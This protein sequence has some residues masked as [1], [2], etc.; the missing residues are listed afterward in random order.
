MK[1]PVIVVLAVHRTRLLRCKVHIRI[2]SQHICFNVENLFIWL[3]WGN[4]CFTT[5]TLCPFDIVTHIRK[6]ISV[7]TRRNKVWCGSLASW[8]CSG[9]RQPKETAYS[10]C[11]GLIFAFLRISST[12]MQSKRTIKGRCFIVEKYSLTFLYDIFPI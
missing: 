9:G 8:W 6:Q 7:I 2:S 11:D 1:G 4:S 3:G 10:T 12:H 5:H